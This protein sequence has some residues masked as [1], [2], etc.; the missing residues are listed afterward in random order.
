VTLGEKAAKVPVA[1]ARFH[2]Q[3]QGAR[4]GAGFG[5]RRDLGADE[6]AQSGAACGLVEA[7]RTADSVTVTQ[8]EGGVAELCRAVDEVLRVRCTFEEGEGATAAQLD[9]IGGHLC[10]FVLF[11]PLVNLAHTPVGHRPRYAAP[12]GGQSG[13]RGVLVA[14]DE[15]L[16][17]RL[18]DRVLRERGFEVTAVGDGKAA[19]ECITA[20]GGERLAVAVVDVGMPPHGGAVALEAMLARRPDLGIVVISGVSPNPALRE[21]L[22]SW[23][24]VFLAK[25]FAPDEVVRAV[26]DALAAR[27]A[28]PHKNPSPSGQSSGE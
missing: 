19:V 13:G 25:P 7:R 21:L 22:T 11:S 28:R 20:P 5:L 17:R 9:V 23:G 14:D 24:G 16:L 27:A 8:G 6:A 10:N 15:P 1:L 4:P 12:V 26:N 18:I 2:E 3:Q